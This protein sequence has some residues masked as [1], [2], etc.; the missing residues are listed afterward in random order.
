MANYWDS[1]EIFLDGDQ[2]FDRLINDIDQAKEY[3]TIEM[4]TFNYDGLGKKI[5]DHLI[6]AHKRG[7]K[8]QIIVDGIGSYDF[9]DKFYGVFSSEGIQAKIF[10]P[11]PFYHPFYGKLLFKKKIQ[12]F[13]ARLWKL[14]Q[15][16]HRKII[17][18][19]FHTMYLGSFNI[20]AEHTSYHTSKK[21]KDMGARVTGANV[22]I[23]ILYFKKIWQLREFF[24]F[25]KLVRQLQKKE[26]KHSPLRLNHS[27]IMRR[28]YSKNLLQKFN[29]SKDKIWLV[30]PY[31]IPT[32]MLILALGRAAQ[33]GV[34][35]RIL[36]S[37]KSDVKIFQSLQFFYVPYLTHKGVKVFQFVETILHAKIVIVDDWMTVGSSNLNHRSILH[38]LEVDLSIQDQNN[39]DVILRDFILSTPPEIEMTPERL[40]Q[41][42]ILDKLLSRLFYLFKYWF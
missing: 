40:K 24:K 39:K 17:T 18:I 34:D 28:F 22:K 41:R 26:S 21:W 5:S 7:V 14:N 20:T 27:L 32:P 16:N 23:A 8:V 9:Y 38:D 1:E 33:R 11:L 3:I 19:D 13:F 31:F 37:S 25:R 12:A 36:L 4:Y 35:V 29:K 10:H 6:E 15:R 2:Y 42:T 30:T